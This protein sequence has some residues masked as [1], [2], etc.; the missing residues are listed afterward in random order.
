MLIYVFQ[1]ILVT[2]SS[3]VPLQ[4]TEEQQFL[5]LDGSHIFFGITAQIFSISI[6]RIVE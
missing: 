2:R 3:K 4:N 6:T 5:R 1:V